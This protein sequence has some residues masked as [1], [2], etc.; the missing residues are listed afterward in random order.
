MKTQIAVLG[1]GG[2]VG[3][4]LIETL[5]LDGVTGV[6][7]VLR[8][9][10][11]MASLCRFGS[12]IEV[13]I[14][15]A[16]DAE[17]LGEA[18][19]GCATVINLTTGAPA[20][21]VRSTKAI[22]SAC[23]AA[24]VRRL[25]HMSSAVVFGEVE[26]PLVD[27][28]SPPLERHWMPYARAKAA[29]EK[30]LREQSSAGVEIVVLRPGIVWGPRSPHT[31]QVVD[32]LRRKCAFLVDGGKGVFNS[33]YI[34]N[35]IA[36]I[37]ACCDDP[38]NPAGFYNIADSEHLTWRDFYEAL[39]PALECD[40]AR[41]ADVSSDRL[42]WSAGAVLEYV[43]SLPLGNGLYHRLKAALPDAAKAMIKGRLAGPYD[44]ERVTTDYQQPSVGRE[45]WRLQQVKHKLPTAKFTQRFGWSPPV[46]FDEGIRRTINWLALLDYTSLQPSC[47][48]T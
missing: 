37:R 20:G 33:V 7:A 26:S 5:V 43:Q 45:L 22:Y 9:P 30:W 14:A 17:S 39:S 12:A 8:A 44:Y 2:Y 48:L 23:Q 31:M 24:Q 19:S 27:D 29:S 16:E 34:D 32:A 25:V 46:T 6:R 15:D 41:I 13:R 11:N 18:L 36:G 1:A 38:G 21:I 47:T 40:I 42:P 4:S 10:R 28:D 3:A 35:L